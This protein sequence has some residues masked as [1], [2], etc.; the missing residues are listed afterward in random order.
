MSVL[1]VAAPETER[2]QAVYLQPGQLHVADSPTAITTILASCVAVCLWD[3]RRRAG[4]MNHF[5]LPKALGLDGAPARFGASAIQLLIDQMVARGSR[6]R[7]LQA[8]LFGGA[9][10]LAAVP[11][12]RDRIPLGDSNVRCAFELLDDARIPV[13][14]SDVGGIRGRKII[15]HTADGSAFMKWL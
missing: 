14:A 3:A 12:N 10:V 11:G 1:A 9:T 4:G 5:L 15:F 2:V 6:M 8:K 7:D 13:V